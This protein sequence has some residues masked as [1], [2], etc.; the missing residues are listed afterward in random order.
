MPK[1]EDPHFRSAYALI[2][3]YARAHQTDATRLAEQRSGT[4]TTTSSSSS[5]PS[6]ASRKGSSRVQL[7]SREQVQRWSDD[8][9]DSSTT[10]SCSIPSYDPREGRSDEGAA[11]IKTLDPDLF[12]D[13]C[14]HCAD[15]EDA[16]IRWVD[17]SKDGENSLTRVVGQACAMVSRGCKIQ[18]ITKSEGFVGCCFRCAENFLC[19]DCTWERTADRGVVPPSWQRT[20]LDNGPV[21][22]ST[23]SKELC[24][25]DWGKGPDACYN[26]R[27]CGYKHTHRPGIRRNRD[28]ER[29]YYG[30]MD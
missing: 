17:T 21:W 29:S 16:R 30:S 3:E 5:I 24:W 25:I 23:T 7:S 1:F 6:S 14:E 2:G 4:T 13:Y 20:Q 18:R 8:R 28:R 19:Y 27:F 12:I 22:R 9:D 15:Y 11:I 10:A 26:G